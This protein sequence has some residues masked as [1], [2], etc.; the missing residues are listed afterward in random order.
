M[1][2]ALKSYQIG[3]VVNLQSNQ[4]LSDQGRDSLWI[5]FAEVRKSRYE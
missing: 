3:Y 5:Y 4:R 1:I 2:R